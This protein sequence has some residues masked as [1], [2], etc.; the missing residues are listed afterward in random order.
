PMA[1]TTRISIDGRITDPDEAFLPL[2]DDGLLRGD[3][4]FEVARIYGGKPFALD[5]HL[6]RMERSA[7][8]IELPLERERLTFEIG[9]MLKS[10]EN[11]DC[12]LRIIQTRSGRRI[13]TIEDLPNHSPTISLATVT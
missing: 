2:P 10:L 6:D 11:P 9:E 5:L 1:A 7:A 3:G 12:L 13:I 8:T 4:V